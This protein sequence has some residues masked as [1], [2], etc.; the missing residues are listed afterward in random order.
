MLQGWNEEVLA[1]ARQILEW[2]ERD[3]CYALTH[4]QAC[5]ATDAAWDFYWSDELVEQIGL[6]Y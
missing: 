2:E 1:W 4:T 6:L 5:T 3:H